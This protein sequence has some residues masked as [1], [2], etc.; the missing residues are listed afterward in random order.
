[1]TAGNI[2]S[3]LKEASVRLPDE[4]AILSGKTGG[5]PDKSFLELYRDVKATAAFLKSKGV[6][7]GDKT[8]LFVP[9]GRYVL[10]VG[11]PHKLY[12]I[13]NSTFNVT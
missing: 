9:F 7:K 1:M 11:N 6:G 8:L 12:F 5:F 13:K 10:G 2:A 3:H 4:K